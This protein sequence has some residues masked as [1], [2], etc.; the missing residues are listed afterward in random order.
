MVRKRTL[1]GAIF[2]LSVLIGIQSVVAIYRWGHTPV[3]RANIEGT[4]PIGDVANP[5]IDLIG[6]KS[7]I[8]TEWSQNYPLSPYFIV[9]ELTIV[10]TIKEDTYHQYSFSIVARR[11][12]DEIGHVYHFNFY[13]GACSE[14]LDFEV[15]NST[16]RMH[17]PITRFIPNDYMT[18]LE[19]WVMS[20]SFEQDFTPE[21]RDAP[22]VYRYW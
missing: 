14:N 16:F 15:E 10:G 18:G 8:S 5:D 2:I 3:H 17:F 19:V 22:I 4:D 20:T 12:S 11:L 1:I 6:Y 21:M 7:Y 13:N 9:L